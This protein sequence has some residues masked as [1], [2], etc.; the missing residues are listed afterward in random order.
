VAY[1]YYFG[2]ITRYTPRNVLLYIY[3]RVFHTSARARTYYA[4]NQY[5]QRGSFVLIRLQT[6]LI[7]IHW[8]IPGNFDLTAFIAFAL[9]TCSRKMYSIVEFDDQW[10]P[11]FYA[12]T[13]KMNELIMN[14][15]T[16]TAG[17]KISKIHIY[18]L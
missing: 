9:K 4:L 13:C 14:G 8:N 12:I 11:R 10:C 15:Y 3:I 5:F 7:F 18:L 16:I 2:G 6:K 17:V 1:E